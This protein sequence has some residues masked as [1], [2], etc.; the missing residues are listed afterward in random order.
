MVFIDSNVA[1]YALDPR[2]ERKREIAERLL[3]DE[4]N[5]RSLVVS[6]QVLVEFANGALAKLRVP[7]AVVKQQVRFLATGQL[8]TVDE[9]IVVAAIE[10]R[11]QYQLSFW[12][13]CIVA[14][15]QHAGCEILYTEDLNHGQVYGTVR[16]VNPF[17]G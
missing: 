10:L 12:D 8:V 14:A 5:R 11:Q 4:L 15:A 7:E 9:R 13:A 6:S 3:V 16:A 2:D 17:A 1:L